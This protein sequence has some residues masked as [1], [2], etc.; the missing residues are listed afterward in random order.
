MEFFS[1]RCCRSKHS[2]RGLS[3]WQLRWRRVSG[4][5]SPRVLIMVAA[6]MLDPADCAGMALGAPRVTLA[7]PAELHQLLTERGFR[8]SSRDDPTIVQEQQH[9]EFARVGVLSATPRQL[10]IPF[11]STELRGIAPSEHRVALARLASLL[12]EA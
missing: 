12:L 2:V 4:T 7:A 5:F 1:Q 6:W 9:E 10:S 11:D 8:R 3:R